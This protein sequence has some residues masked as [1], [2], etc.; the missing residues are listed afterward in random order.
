MQSLYSIAH[1]G[2]GGT[3]LGPGIVTTHERQ[4]VSPT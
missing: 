2:F 3:G 1:G 4:Q